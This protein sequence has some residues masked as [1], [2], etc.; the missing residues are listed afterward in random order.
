MVGIAVDVDA[1]VVGL[2]VLVTVGE[3]DVIAL[4]VDVDAVVKTVDVDGLGVAV[5]VLVGNSVVV[6]VVVFIN[7]TYMILIEETIIYY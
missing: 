3:V 2:F 4:I 6:N 5:D 7:M 1:L